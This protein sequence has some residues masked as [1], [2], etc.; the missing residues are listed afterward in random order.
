[1]SW[2]RIASHIVNLGDMV[3]RWTNDRY[4]STVHRYEWWESDR[5]G[6]KRPLFDPTLAGRR[7]HLAAAMSNR[8]NRYVRRHLSVQADPAAVAAGNVA[9]GRHY[10]AGRNQHL[11]PRSP[12]IDITTGRRPTFAATSLSCAIRQR[13]AGLYR[14]AGGPQRALATSARDAKAHPLPRHLCAR[15]RPCST[16]IASGRAHRSLFGSRRAKPPRAL[17]N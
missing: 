11:G 8:R 7:H 10:V 9:D 1:L 6:S 4:R 15:Q 13:A 3:A 16:I 14:S 5:H 2:T 12:S 17:T